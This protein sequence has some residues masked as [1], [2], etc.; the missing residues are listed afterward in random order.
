MIIDQ[1]NYKAIVEIRNPQ[2]YWKMIW[3]TIVTTK[4]PSDKNILYKSFLDCSLQGNICSNIKLYRLSQNVQPVRILIISAD[5][6][7]ANVLNSKK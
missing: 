4:S 7:L 3:A 2:L 1:Q 6:F 5:I